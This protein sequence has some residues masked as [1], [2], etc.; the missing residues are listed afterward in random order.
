[1]PKR[2][3]VVVSSH[4]AWSEAGR[5]TGYWVGEVSHFC[6]L[7]KE[8]GFEFDVVSPQGGRAPMD[9]KSA[10]GFQSWDG[11]YRAYE[12]NPELQQK[13]ENTLRPDQVRA[14]D[15]AAIYYTGGHG[16]MWD[17]PGN[18]QLAQ[19]AA[20]LYEQGKV[21]AAVCHGVTGLLDVKLSD[22]DVH[23]RRRPRGAPAPEAGRGRS[24]GGHGIRRVTS[25]GRLPSVSPTGR[26]SRSSAPSLGGEEHL[27]GASPFHRPGERLVHL[28]Q[29][30][31]GVHRSVEG[32]A[33]HQGGHAGVE[34][35][36]LLV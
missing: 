30:E 7:L 34:G 16:T 6:E 22:Q 23:P 18:A 19:L 12:R 28:V 3:L 31:G 1:M 2:I 9:P 20:R 4:A 25:G 33:G 11:G 17:F 27:S 36:A 21:V 32:A 13:L 10:H 29:A 35:A 5:Q 14:E 26:P 15:Y 24:A 8:E